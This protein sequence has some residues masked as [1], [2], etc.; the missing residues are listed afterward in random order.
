[1]SLKE[2]CQTKK[3]LGTIKEHVA[4]DCPN[5]DLV[6]SIIRQL[7]LFVE[8][9]DVAS[10]DDH[11]NS[12]IENAILSMCSYVVLMYQDD[13]EALKC[14]QS[15]LTRFNVE[16]EVALFNL[17]GELRSKKE[18]KFAEALAICNL[19]EQALC[20]N[21]VEDDTNTDTDTVLRS[22]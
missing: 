7:D 18:G 1:M 17:A 11:L 6:L 13:I 15:A 2:I 14:L 4:D 20:S 16:C 3:I 8:N 9:D 22:S 19:V 21:D 10:K 12:K 5:K